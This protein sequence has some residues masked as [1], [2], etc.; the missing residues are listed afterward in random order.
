MRVAVV[1]EEG[2][3]LE[4]SRDVDALKRRHGTGRG[5]VAAPP[6][7]W[8]GT[9]FRDWSF[10][11]LPGPVELERA[12]ARQRLF[13]GIHD[14]GQSVSLRLF[15]TA[16]DAEAA[17]RH[18][19]LRL[20]VLALPQQ[21]RELVARARGD[22]EL[23]L[24]GREL[25][26]DQDLAESVALAAFEGT[27]LPH[28]QLLP[29]DAA[30][31]RDR[32]Q[33]GRGRMLDD[34]EAFIRLVREIL[35]LRAELRSRLAAG[36]TGPAAAE[37]AADLASQL[38]GLVHPGFL[39][40]VHAGRLQHYPRYLRAMLVRIERL[41]QGKGEARQLLELKPHLQRLADA[42]AR[43][44][45]GAEAERAVEDFRWMVEELRVSLFAQQLG[46]VGKTSGARLESQWA[47]VR[48]L[49]AGMPAPH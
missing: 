20:F 16:A 19:I 32:F 15:A 30:G 24:R 26:A 7:D 45:P 6:G 9:G 29:S 13:P 43:H 35:A 21:F 34:G 40:E 8:Q 37:A 1:D 14:D 44:W 18:G 4:A 36:L 28:G 41:A 25:D 3:L 12:G 11:S 49:E 39:R 31:F 33:A 27:F 48:A 10:G 38:D 47:R 23:V 42:R 5:P 46:T 2:T 22:R 17:S